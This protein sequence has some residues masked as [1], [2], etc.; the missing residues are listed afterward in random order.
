MSRRR[1]EPTLLQVENLCVTFT[2]PEGDL[3]AV[4]GVNITVERGK[5]LGIAGE[6]G[7]GKSVMARTLL[8]LLPRDR[9][10]L[11]GSV[12]F[13]GVELT[14]L[15][16]KELRSYRGGQ[17][18]MVF[19]D[20]MR[21]LNPI[22]TVGAQVAEAISAHEKVSRAAAKSRVVELLSLVRI[23]NP[24]ERFSSY[25]H[26]LSGGMRQR[27]MIAM[28][29]ACRPS[30]LVADEPT[31]AL[32]VT[33]QVAIMSL[34]GDLQEEFGM[35]LIFITHDLNLAASYTDEV[36][37][38]YAGRVVERI[39]SENVLTQLRM[40]YAK[41]LIDSIPELD[42][43]PHSRL[44]AVQGVRPDPLALPPG[45]AF[46]PRCPYASDKCRHDTPVLTEG[47]PGHSWACWNPLGECQS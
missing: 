11:T 7:S 43:E 25:P 40:P 23:P 24:A 32:D 3:R 14:T 5:T 34:L 20:P 8:G 45:C 17:I 21:S 31:T 22:K 6:S 2:L 30:L 41:A 44:A 27:V 46:H 36:A 16:E 13:N 37:V 38:M 19:Q 1:Q 12:R 47:S 28:A 42:A 4:D 33:T 26:Q 39:S 10:R 9:V 29:L 35:A 18:A 15:S